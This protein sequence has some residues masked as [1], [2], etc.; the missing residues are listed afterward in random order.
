MADSDIGYCIFK[1]DTDQVNM[2]KKP[3]KPKGFE[4]LEYKFTDSNGAHYY[5]HKDLFDI[6]LERFGKLNEY[7]LQLQRQLSNAELEGFIEAIEKKV[8]EALHDKENYYK[9]LAKISVLLEEMNTR[10]DNILHSELMY[11]VASVCYVRED[12]SPVKFDAE[13]HSEKVRL[14]RKDNIDKEYDFFVDAGLTEYLPFLPQLEKGFSRL[15]GGMD[16]QREAT[17]KAVS[18]LA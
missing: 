16:L 9:P 18:Q 2:S 3:K 10:K 1:H 11:D 13:I 5:A 17:M 15:L 8:K 14:F 4:K 12:E 6:P 7:V